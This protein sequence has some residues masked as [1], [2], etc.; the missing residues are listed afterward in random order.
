MS[1]RDRKIK[2]FMLL[3]R[4]NAGLTTIEQ[5]NDSR[6]SGQGYNSAR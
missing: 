6:D 5:P 2:P 1:D 3:P 4:S